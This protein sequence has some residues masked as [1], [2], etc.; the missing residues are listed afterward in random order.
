MSGMV[1][2]VNPDGTRNRA[3]RPYIDQEEYKRYLHLYDPASLHPMPDGLYDRDRP[4]DCPSWQSYFNR[5][6]PAG[7]AYTLVGSRMFFPAGPNPPRG[8][9][10]GGISQGRGSNRTG[11]Y[12][13]LTSAYDRPNIDQYPD[14]NRTG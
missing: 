6:K 10:T 8:H 2:E 12:T 14:F 13:N 11:G 9:R 7:D 5:N 1:V 3:Y 4:C